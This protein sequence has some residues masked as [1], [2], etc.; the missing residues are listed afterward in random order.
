MFQMRSV[1]I[2]SLQITC[3]ILECSC[4]KVHEKVVIPIP[5]VPMAQCPKLF[6]PHICRTPDEEFSFQ[7]DF[8]TASCS[9]TFL[10][11][12][13]DR[14]YTVAYYED[15][16][17]NVR[18]IEVDLYCDIQDYFAIVEDYRKNLMRF[19]WSIKGDWSRERF[20]KNSN[21]FA[22]KDGAFI[23]ISVDYKFYNPDSAFMIHIGA[24]A[25]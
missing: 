10:L 4:C 11:N 22:E 21:A 25:H 1:W 16:C 3:V 5:L 14:Y 13:T 8:T 15:Q 20:T 18:S 23:A 17:S 19:G 2:L 12:D 6:E 24:N 9:D 7:H